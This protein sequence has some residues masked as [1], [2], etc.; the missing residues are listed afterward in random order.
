MRPLPPDELLDPLRIPERFV[1]AGDLLE[2]VRETFLFPDGALYN[3]EHRHLQD[4]RIAALWTNVAQTR[5]GMV[6]AATAEI[7]KPTQGSPWQKARLRCQL[8]EWFGGQPD[9][10]LTFDAVIVGEAP[11]RAFCALVD[12]EL[13]HCGQAKDEFGSPKYRKDGSPVYTMRGHDV[14]EFVGVVRR[15][16]AAGVLNP[17]VWRLAEAAKEAPEVP[18]TAVRLAC[19]LCLV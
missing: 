19:G 9:F 18:D 5:Q 15:F 6:V 7:P 1:P 12:H 16:G 14:E 3:P 2:W 17:D 8:E 13:Y 10:L 4:A 11:E